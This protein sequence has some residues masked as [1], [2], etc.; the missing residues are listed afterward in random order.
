M[1]ILR[2]L[3]LLVVTDL[4][5]IYEVYSFRKCCNRNSKRQSSTFIVNEVSISAP[6]K[7]LSFKVNEADLFPGNFMYLFNS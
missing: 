1:S 7:L 3:M 4:C 5:I 6:T 2:F